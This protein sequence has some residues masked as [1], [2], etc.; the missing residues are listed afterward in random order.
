MVTATGAPL[1]DGAFEAH[2]TVRAADAGP[3]ERYAAAHGLEFVR[4]VLDRGRVTDQPMLTVRASGTFAAVRDSIV[5][6]A[7][8]LDAAGLPVVRVK[9]EATPT[10][11]G[12]PATD[13]QAVALGSGYYFEHHIKL[14]LSAGADLSR[15]A[16]LAIAHAAH[17]SVNARRTRG[18]GRTERFLTH[19]CRL[20]GDAT[21]A[22][23]Y[24]E[25]LSAL[26]AADYEILSAEREFVVLDTDETIDAGWIIE[27]GNRP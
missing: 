23:R 7:A 13:A 11:A 19:R 20:V 2:L 3:L 26:R 9:I 1:F 27:E 5:A 21:A 10:T 16:E 15:L 18:D 4:I 17:L 22:A 25:L 6:V 24:S 12:V 8:R 14:L